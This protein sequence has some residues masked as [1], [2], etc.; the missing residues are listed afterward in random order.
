MR[1]TASELEMVKAQRQRH[2]TEVV[3]LHRHIMEQ[4]PCQNCGSPAGVPCKHDYGCTIVDRRT[5]DS[6]TLF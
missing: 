6:M 1:E 3:R 5:I 4:L 2:Y